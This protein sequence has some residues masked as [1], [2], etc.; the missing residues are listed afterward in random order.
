V[1]VRQERLLDPRLAEA[2]AP[3]ELLARQVDRRSGRNERAKRNLVRADAL[4]TAEVDDCHPLL[5]PAR[6][7]R[8]ARVPPNKGS[9]EESHPWVATS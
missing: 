8:G 3:D 5:L 7:P 9:Q 4:T 2:L 1:A 6:P